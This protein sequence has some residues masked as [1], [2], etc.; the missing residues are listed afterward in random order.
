MKQNNTIK[1]NGHMHLRVIKGMLAFALSVVM[2]FCTIP[3]LN[4]GV[5][6]RAAEAENKISGLGTGSI[7]NPSN[8]NGGWSKVYFGSKSTPILFN[9][10]KVGETNF[11]GSTLFMDSA[12]V[13]EEQYFD[14][15]R[16]TN[17]WEQ[18]DIRVW[19]NKTLKNYR[20][21]N[22]EISAIASSRKSAKGNGDGSGCSD[23]EWAALDGDQIFLLDA[24]E[25]TNAS[26]GFA[27]TDAA[28]AARAKN[29]NGSQSV[30][31]LR[32][33]G[34]DRADCAGFVHYNGRIHYSTADTDGIGVSPAININMSSVM[35]ASLINA[36]T[37]KLTVIDQDS[38]GNALMSISSSGAKQKGTKV[39]VP[40]TITGD[41]ANA[42]T[43]VSV[44]VTTATWSNTQGWST[45]AA[46]LLYTNLDTDSWNT[47]GS[48]TFTLDTAKV[49]GTWGT[50][51]KVYLVAEDV[52]GEKETDYSSTPVELK[53]NEVEIE[54]AG[55]A[56]DKESAVLVTK[57]ALNKKSADLVKG[58][59]LVLKAK[60]S[61]SKA[62]N[63]KVTW[64][65]S[66]K[67]V[68]TVDK[69][70]KVTAVKAGKATITATASD[71][72]KKSASCKITVTNPVKVKSI[73]LD[74]TKISI[75]KEKTYTIK[76]KFTPKN[77]TNKGLSYSS[78][79]KKVASVDKNGKIKALKKGS[80]IIT[81]TA[82]DGK[83]TAMCKVTVK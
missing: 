72:S 76:V 64:K 65:S 22:S 78:S 26:Y 45:N 46:P 51:Y 83:K 2:T 49:S 62:A 35:F 80:A 43:Q 14:N 42:A 4:P 39:T 41:H 40:Y 29:L 31:W 3:K 21:T 19:L 50:D 7:G 60:V 44:V 75:K 11:G 73:K 12:D 48:G 53:L 68:A 20:F 27:D 6:V 15:N 25:V 47:Q 36:G 56:T 16:N 5:A 70:G 9:V 24:A 32:S 77:A 52:N 82:K 55:K 17:I 34:P 37:Y 79:N 23:L 1:E 59:T 74:K 30:W 58:K 13:I 81:V 38:Q 28:N 69:N 18:S 71:G 54:E 8:G 33:K 61:P 66:N 63:R 57:V 10:L 67:K